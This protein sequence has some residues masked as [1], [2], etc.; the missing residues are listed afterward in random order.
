[1]WSPFIRRARREPW[2]K[3]KL[4]GQKA[5]HILHS[6]ESNGINETS[7]VPTARNE[8]RVLQLLQVE[9]QGWA[10]DQSL[11]RSIWVRPGLEEYWLRQIQ[12][13]ARNR[14]YSQHWPFVE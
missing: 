5:H 3:G 13:V 8:T 4:I 9:G 11:A 12:P 7:S 2:N 1:M 14:C 10:G 6:V